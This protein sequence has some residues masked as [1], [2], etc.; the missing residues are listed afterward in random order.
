M[1]TMGLEY[2]E[3]PYC[4]TELPS[5]G[6]NNFIKGDLVYLASGYLTVSTAYNQ[7]MA[8]ALENDSAVAGT[9]ISVLIIMPGTKFRVAASATTAQT[10]CGIGGPMTYTSGSVAVTP[11]TSHTSHEEF[12]VEQLDPRDGATTGAGGRVIGRFNILSCGLAYVAVT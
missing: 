5:T 7:I 12:I 2:V 4:V 1:A 9:M 10:N 3:G 8:V 11:E 6:S